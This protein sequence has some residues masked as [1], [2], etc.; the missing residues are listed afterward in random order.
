MQI[1]PKPAILVKLRTTAWYTVLT[2]V[3]MISSDLPPFHFHSMGHDMKSSGTSNADAIDR[4]RNCRDKAEFIER[5]NS[6]RGWL[7][8]AHGFLDDDGNITI[9]LWKDIPIRRP[10]VVECSPE[11][12]SAY[13]ARVR[14]C[15]E[16]D[17]GQVD[18]EADI[19]WALSDLDFRPYAHP[20]MRFYEPKMTWY[21]AEASLDPETLPEPLPQPLQPPDFEGTFYSPDD[22]QGQAHTARKQ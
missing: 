20:V 14:E 4:T 3:S 5:I 18:F 15:Q 17:S 16:T 1:T 21:L 12:L 8:G 2:K 19:D 10:V 9:D 7:V 11:I 13:M 22:D 6:A